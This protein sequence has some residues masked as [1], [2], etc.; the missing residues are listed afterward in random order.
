MILILKPTDRVPCAF[1]H[2][3][4]VAVSTFSSGSQLCT[5]WKQRGCGQIVWMVERWGPCPARQSIPASHSLS[6][7]AD[8]VKAKVFLE[9]E[10]NQDLTLIMSAS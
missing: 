10:R 8:L 3:S 2:R 9:E 5:F 6:Q 1:C 7:R 4:Q